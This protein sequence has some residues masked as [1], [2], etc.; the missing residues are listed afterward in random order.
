MGISSKWIK[1]L[2]G[3]R[4]QEKAQNAEK[5]EK[6]WNAE[7]D[8]CLFVMSME[9]QRHNGLNGG[10]MVQISGSGCCHKLLDLSPL[11]S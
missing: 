9:T 10:A 6:G 11:A 7:R 4:K 8:D 2:V 5:Q 1:S 3:I